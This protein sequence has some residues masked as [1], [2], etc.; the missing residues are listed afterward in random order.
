MNLETFINNKIFFK[1][2]GN[3]FT[4]GYF[5]HN[6]SNKCYFTKLYTCLVI[7]KNFD[8]LTFK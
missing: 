7:A 5:T 1:T 6:I 4:I 2:D 3:Y 8:T